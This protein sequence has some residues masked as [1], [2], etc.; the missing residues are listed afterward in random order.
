MMKLNTK[1]QK[2]ILPQSNPANDTPLVDEGTSNGTHEA[3]PRLGK[4]RQS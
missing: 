1:N 3:R 2:E 4:W